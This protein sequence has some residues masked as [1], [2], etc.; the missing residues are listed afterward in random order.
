MKIKK[1]VSLDGT[2][3]ELEIP[4]EGYED[5]YARWLSGEGD[6]QN[7]L[8]HLTPAQREFLMTGI[9]QEQWDDMFKPKPKDLT[10][11]GF[12]VCD[13]GNGCTAWQKEF[14]DGSYVHITD[15]ELMEHELFNKK[16]SVGFYSREGAVQMWGKIKVRNIE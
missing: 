3:N 13:I 6:I 7:M 2:L 8:P 10:K 12:T 5:M 4:L 15:S 9:A 14:K 11:H 1:I 16:A